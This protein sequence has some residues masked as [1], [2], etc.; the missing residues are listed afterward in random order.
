MQVETKADFF[1]VELEGRPAQ[2]YN[3]AAFRFF[4][5]SEQKR[6][7]R[8]GRPFALVLVER[9]KESGLGARIDVEAATRLFS[10]LSLGLR[11]TDFVGWYEEGVVAGAVL[12]HL[13]E[14][15]KTDV[16]HQV[17]RRIANG[18]FA[19]LFPEF[20]DYFT[21]RVYELPAQEQELDQN[22]N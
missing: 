20:A 1:R 15:S 21:L 7:D 6:S 16:A 3:Q 18:V 5:A 9:K 11:E 22:R 13:G 8:S 10:G 4:L 19:G 14:T 2:V 12:T 17:H